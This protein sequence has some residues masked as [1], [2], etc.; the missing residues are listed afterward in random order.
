[1]ARKVQ[2]P[3]LIDEIDRRVNIDYGVSDDRLD[4]GR[5]MVLRQ[6]L[7]DLLLDL[8]MCEL[9]ETKKEGD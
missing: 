4:V 1:M 9:A 2:Y 8:G 7:I 3:A 5:W 6:P